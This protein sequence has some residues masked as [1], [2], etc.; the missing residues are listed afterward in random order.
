MY[1]KIKGKGKP[2]CSIHHGKISFHSCKNNPYLIISFLGLNTFSFFSQLTGK[3]KL[4]GEKE[5]CFQIGTSEHFFL[6]DPLTAC[7]LGDCISHLIIL[8]FKWN[9]VSQLLLEQ[10]MNG[11]FWTI[12]TQKKHFSTWVI[13]EKNYLQKKWMAYPVAMSTRTV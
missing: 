12:F 13:S 7:L 5:V 1:A 6:D 2:G 4:D 9:Q 10:E 8:L 11:L 3:W